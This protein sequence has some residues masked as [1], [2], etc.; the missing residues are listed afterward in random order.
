M[1]AVVFIHAFTSQ[2]SCFQ[3]LV[4][5]ICGIAVPNFFFISGGF[6]LCR[7]DT[8]EHI[9]TYYKRR[10]FKII[11]PTVLTELFYVSYYLIFNESGIKAKLI[12]E[13][14]YWVQN[15]IAGNAYHLWFMNVI[16]PFY[17]VAPLLIYIRKKNI[18]MYFLI[19]VAWFVFSECNFYFEIIKFPWYFSFLNYIS[20]MLLGDIIKNIV[21]PKKQG[22][23][24]YVYIVLFIVCIV[25][26]MIL[27]MSLISGRAISFAE[28]VLH[29]GARS[30]IVVDPYTQQCINL[31]AS[32]MIYCFFYTVKVNAN[33]LHLADFCFYIYLIHY[34]L[35]DICLKVIYMALSAF[36]IYVSADILFIVR[37]CLVLFVSS[38][39]VYF[40]KMIFNIFKI[41]I[42]RKKVSA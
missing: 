4:L 18:K 17:I 13:A 39:I 35:E 33:F 6:L 15:G 37:A 40:G 9:G 30:N 3:Q 20:F 38:M 1:I 41:I 12:E 34:L 19:S 29:D 14:N 22:N 42:D 36:G 27:K 31:F 16:I 11:V 26:E 8:L 2:T 25:I 32:V 23:F 7:Y 10:F 21:L 28:F 24:R 5:M